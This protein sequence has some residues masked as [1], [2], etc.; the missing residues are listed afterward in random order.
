MKTKLS[1]YPKLRYILN[2]ILALILLLTNAATMW[3]CAPE[4]D[5]Y[6]TGYIGMIVGFFLVLNLLLTGIALF[7]FYR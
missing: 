7:M 1:N 2:R 6:I 5:K 3:F 4:L